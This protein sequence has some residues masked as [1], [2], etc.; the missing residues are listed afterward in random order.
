MHKYTKKSCS[1]RYAKM[2]NLVRNELRRRPNLYVMSICIIFQL[3]SYK[4]VYKIPN[5]NAYRLISTNQRPMGIFSQVLLVSM[6][7]S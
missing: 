1:I 3:D 6:R 5:L 2:V 7:Q 4:L